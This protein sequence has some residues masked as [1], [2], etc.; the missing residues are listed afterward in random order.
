MLTAPS[1]PVMASSC[2]TDIG[3]NV[4]R[5]KFF[6]LIASEQGDGNPSLCCI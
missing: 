5:F 3:V 4:I 2:Q 6:A 1:G